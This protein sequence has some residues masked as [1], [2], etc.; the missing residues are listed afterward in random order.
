MSTPGPRPVF[1]PVFLRIGD[2]KEDIEIGTLEART[3]R[4][5]QAAM[6]ALLRELADGL[7]GRCP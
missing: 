6:P 1:L 2:E 7:E 5:A 3:V 4:E